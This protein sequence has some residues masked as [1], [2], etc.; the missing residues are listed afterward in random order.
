MTRWIWI[1]VVL[2]IANASC[3][4]R[5]GSGTRDKD[6]DGS[7][8]LRVSD[9]PQDIAAAKR[10]GASQKL[11]DDDG[12]LNHPEQIWYVDLETEELLQQNRD[13]VIPRLIKVIKSPTQEF[14]ERLRAATLL[15]RLRDNRGCEAVATFLRSAS[16]DNR[17][18]VLREL[19]SL[20]SY[21]DPSQSHAQFLLEAPGMS[22]LLIEQLAHPDPQVKKAA[23]QAIG[24]LD[25]P[26]HIDRF[27]VL[28]HQ[29]GY[30]DRGRLAYWLA[31][32]GDVVAVVDD[33]EKYFR[34]GMTDADVQNTVA[35]LSQ[36]AKEGSDS[37]RVRVIQLVREYYERNDIDHTK[38][39]SSVGWQ[40]MS[41]V[42]DYAG[43]EYADWLKARLPKAEPNQQGKIYKALT[44]MEANGW[45]PLI[46]Q[47][48]RT[49]ETTI[50]ASQAIADKFRGTED[51]EMVDALVSSLSDADSEQTVSA[52]CSALISIG[53]ER[54][55]LA[56]EKRL[57]QI[58]PW[59]RMHLIWELRGI[60][61]EN[62]RSRI[63][64]S[65]L[66]T[67]A[68]VELAVSKTE[69]DDI[70]GTAQ[71]LMLALL[72]NADRLLAFDVE[73]GTL[74]CRHDQ[75]LFD[76]AN[77][78][79]GLFQPTHVSETWNQKDEDEFEADYTLRF[80]ADGRYYEGRLRNYGDWYDVERLIALANQALADA[81]HAERFVA[82]HSDGQVGFFTFGVPESLKRFA[83]DI[84]LPI[85]DDSNRAMNEGK[86]FEQRV[87]E[88]YG[89]QG[90][91]VR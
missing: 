47:A 71:S 88:K 43:L 85:D 58:D 2:A 23:I 49:K 65:S 7:A 28:I 66:L 5:F 78:T 38:F 51:V 73:T 54:A 27:R 46:L 50:D 40:L 36:L 3:S 59:T 69:S 53:G 41:I 14:K 80:V 10:L 9:S 89:G 62:I 68:E 26:T 79:R 13:S 8:W 24:M 16:T 57:D 83:Q 90:A 1:G 12:P 11:A 39:E 55:R 4:S 56:V 6:A 48:L 30:P 22:E 84:A 67:D 64:E 87:L 45:K 37:V 76:F 35:A 82:L 18:A 15:I 17:T 81:E 19:A 33:I 21:G 91:V 77:I 31:M 61:L 63:V 72:L 25:T 75:L 20:R 70:D 52:I 60:T 34:E 32:H 42:A 86:E 44:R 74:P 29:D